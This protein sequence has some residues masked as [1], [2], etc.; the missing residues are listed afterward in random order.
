MLVL[1]RKPGEGIIITLADGDEISIWLSRID[2]YS[3]KIG[4][5]ADRE[6][7]ILRNELI[8]FPINKGR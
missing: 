2:N 3:A 8:P 1:S 5:I 4:I 6:H 7:R